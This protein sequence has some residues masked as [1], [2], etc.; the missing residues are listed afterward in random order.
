LSPSFYRFGFKS[1][2]QITPTRV[3]DALAQMPIVDHVL[4]LQILDHNHV[5]GDNQGAR[6]LTQEILSSVLGSFVLTLE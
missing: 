2:S 5:V 1:L 6:Q 3:G 4:D